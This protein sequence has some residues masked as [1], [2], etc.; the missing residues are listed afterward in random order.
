MTDTTSEDLPEIDYCEFK[1]SLLFWL[2]STNYVINLNYYFLHETIEEVIE[3][4][5][6]L[7]C[8][9][10]CY[11]N[12]NNEYFNYYFLFSPL[13]NGRFTKD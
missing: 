4:S 12:N 8:V 1:E 11:L 5:Y 6:A 10:R 3:S 2:D 9:L 7:Y 13:T